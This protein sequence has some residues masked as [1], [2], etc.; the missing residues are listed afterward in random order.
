MPIY[1][2]AYAYMAKLMHIRLYSLQRVDGVSKK[3]LCCCF[4]RM[5]PMLCIYHLNATTPQETKRGA[6]R[7]TFL[8]LL[9]TVGST[10]LIISMPPLRK[11]QG[12]VHT[13]VYKKARI[14]K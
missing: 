3:F 13:H 1:A 7:H 9:A 5:Q 2:K 4:S 12:W 6:E 10:V 14:N 8:L 11:K